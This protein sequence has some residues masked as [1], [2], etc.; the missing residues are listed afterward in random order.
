M[1]V[2]RIDMEKYARR[3]HFEYFTSLPYPYVGVTNQVDVTELVHICREKQLSFYLM[4]LHA[5]ALAADQVPEM[6]QRIHDGGIVEY[7]ECPTSHTELLD[8]GAYCYCTLHHHMPLAAYLEN[9]EAARQQ[10]RQKGSIEE[11]D[12]VESMYFISTLPWLS[13]TALIQPVAGG[14]ESNPRITWGKFAE[15]TRGRQQMPVSLLAHHALVDGVHIAAF[16]QQLEQQLRILVSE[17]A[18]G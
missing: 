12:D 7:S 10:C 16:Y 14:E 8:N 2:I 11:D 5:A 13:Y 4:F 18:A 3:Q 15:D 1:S 9:A 6:R 17:A